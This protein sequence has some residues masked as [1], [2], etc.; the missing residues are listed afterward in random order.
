[1][2]HGPR[3][4]NE[5][6]RAWHVQARTRAWYAENLSRVKEL[7]QLEVYLGDRSPEPTPEELEDMAE[8][9]AELVR[10]AGK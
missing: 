7:P 8:A 4:L 3:E 1:M 9:H 5:R 2:L 10:K 6:S